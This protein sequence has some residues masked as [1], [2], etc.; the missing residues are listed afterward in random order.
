MRYKKAR[1][2]LF[3]DIGNAAVIS[4]YRR[5]AQRH[6]L[7]K[8][9][10]ESLAAARQREDIGPSVTGDELLAR[11]SRNKMESL[12]DA[13]SLRKRLKTRPVIAIPDE[14]EMQIRS[15]AQE[16]WQ[17]A[18]QGVESL[19]SFGR[20]PPPHGQHVSRIRNCRWQR[21]F[22]STFRQFENCGIHS[23]RTDANLRF[24]EALDLVKLPGGIAAR[25][26]HD[27]R[28]PQANAAQRAHRLP[29]FN[30]MS[31]HQQAKPLRSRPHRRRRHG[32]MRMRRHDNPR[33]ASKRHC[34]RR[35]SPFRSPKPRK[36][37]RA[38]GN[39]QFMLASRIVQ[40]KKP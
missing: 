32:Q 11:K 27:I 15:I 35:K 16:P 29:N 5:L 3:D 25:S 31:L 33:A 24:R 12:L 1:D 36:S 20:R 26:R 21:E 4:T 34:T 23:P 18:N 19:I 37:H 22:R 2:P 8:D 13:H 7:K 38:S 10:S 40:G 17:N 6:G 30:A 39:V 9:E 28:A 14:Y